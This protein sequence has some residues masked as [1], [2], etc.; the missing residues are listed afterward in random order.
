[1][2]QPMI[3]DILLRA[4]AAL[5]I[6]L[7]LPATAAQLRLN[8]TRVHL[9]A[10]HRVETLTLSNEGEDQVS[11]EVAVKRWTMAADGQWQLAPSDDLIVHPLILTIPAGSDGRLRIGTLAPQV[12]QEQAY[13]IELQQLPAQ[14]TEDVAQIKVLTRISLPV[15]LQPDAAAPQVAIASARL[16]AGTLRLTLANAGSGY[17]A[18]QG[19][20]L[21]VLD[22]A[23]QPLHESTIDVGYLL[24]GARL[25]L[26]AT[27]PKSACA[28]ATRIELLLDDPLPD[29]SRPEGPA[30]L[31]TALAPALRRCTP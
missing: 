9:D 29:A 5:C 1:M 28:R 8:P 15:F 2:V 19:A 13:R 31:D 24:A 30:R 4:S 17:L 22:A 20:R 21:R 14:A 18:P 16:D 23:G 7:A 3:R 6:L 25:P 12:A 27:V 11:F 26:T 10:A